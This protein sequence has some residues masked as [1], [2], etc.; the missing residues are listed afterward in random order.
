MKQLKT[1]QMG[2]RINWVGV[3]VFI[4]VCMITYCGTW[5]YVLDREN[6]RIEKQLFEMDRDQKAR[7]LAEKENFE[8][9]NND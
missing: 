5:I 2:T 6:D 4:C 3:F 7:E 9:E 1:K 8:I